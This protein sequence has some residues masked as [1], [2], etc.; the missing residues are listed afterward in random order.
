[1]ILVLNNYNLV[2]RTM[3][4]AIRVI[5][6]VQINIFFVYKILSMSFE[7]PIVR[8]FRAPVSEWVSVSVINVLLL[9]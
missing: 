2:I 3:V 5:R 4:G 8:I 6:S 1:M 7:T 9:E